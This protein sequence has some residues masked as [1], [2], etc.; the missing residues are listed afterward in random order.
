MARQPE[1]LNDLL[2]VIKRKR[3]L[4]RGKELNDRQNI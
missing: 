4:S 2:P 3:E 1:L